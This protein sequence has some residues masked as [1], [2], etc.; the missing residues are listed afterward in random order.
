MWQL[1]LLPSVCLLPSYFRY[2]ITTDCA[3]SD[4]MKL[5]TLSLATFATSAAATNLFV[6]T[7]GPP[8]FI[9]S[10]KLSASAQGG[11]TLEST[12][13]NNGSAPSPSW[14]TK[15][16]H[17][18]IVY[19]V[20]E[21][22]SGGNGSIASYQKSSSGQLTIID[23]HTTMPGGVYA[24]VYNA[25]KSIAVPHYGGSALSSWN[26]NANGSLSPSQT[27]TFT[28]APNGRDVP[29]PHEALLDPSGSFIVV[30]DLGSDLLRVFSIDNSTSLL[31]EQTSYAV[32]NG[33]GPRHGAFLR[34]KCGLTYLFVVTEL[35]PTITSYLVTY[36]GK[37]LSFKPVFTNTTYGGPVP[38]PIAGFPG[39]PFAAELVI[40]PDSQY[41]LTSSRAD[42]FF[43]IANFDKTNSTKIPS[44][45][46]QVWSINHATGA[47]QFKQIA[48]AG[49][50]YPRQFSLNKNG[51][52][53][54]VVLQHDSRVVVIE[55]KSDGTFGDFVAH[56]DIAGE[57]SSVIFDE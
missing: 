5:P 56:V 52:L 41:I 30:P 28:E 10:L 4:N 24:A 27:F 22:L 32:V 47:L 42:Q 20:D 17:N 33:T 38:A 48:P 50:N 21:N 44:D 23:R 57:V 1:S 25:G 54:A 18:N 51:T 45:S 2:F 34:T 3:N 39:G 49:G 16:T 9:A 6:S 15:N 14:L 53:A 43:Q 12:S 31:T 7:Y 11:Y 37:G 13:I 8:G 46:L 19:C 35:K 26:V 29:H 55:R 40:T 36:T